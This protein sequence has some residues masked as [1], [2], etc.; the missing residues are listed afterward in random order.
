MI[1]GQSEKQFAF[2]FL[3]NS[4]QKKHGSDVSESGYSE[5]ESG[6]IVL[7]LLL[8]LFC[9]CCCFYFVFYLSEIRKKIHRTAT[10]RELH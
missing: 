4:E 7:L 6:S 9:C 10:E 8:L 1:L 3:L 2:D 5:T